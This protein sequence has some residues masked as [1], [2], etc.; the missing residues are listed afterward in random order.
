MVNHFWQSVDAIL[1]DVPVTETIVW[2][3]NIDFKT[4]TFQCPQ[5]E[6]S[7]TLVTRLKVEL[8]MA[9]LISLNENLP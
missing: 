5:N 2:W 4:I 6:G 7:S 9:D 3:W 1:E 8:N